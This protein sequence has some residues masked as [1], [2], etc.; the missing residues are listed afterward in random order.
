M[1]F[2]KVIHVSKSRLSYA[3]DEGTLH[4]RI[5]VG[6]GEAKGITVRA[7]DP[8]DWVKKEDSEEYIF[9]FSTARDFEM[10]KECE[11]RYHDVWFGEI[12]GIDTLRI[13][14]AFFID[15]TDG[16]QY[17]YGAEKGANLTT[18][19]TEI[20][21]IFNYFNF[22]YLNR[23]DVYHAPDWVKDTIWYQLSVNCYS[24][25]GMPCLDTRDG[26]FNGLIRKLDYIRE[27]GCSG[28]YLTPVFQSPSYHKYDTRDY[29]NV[30]E[31]MGGNAEFARF[32]K[33]AHK[34]GIRVMLDAVFNHCG[35][36]HPF[37]LDVVKNGEASKYFDCFYILDRSRPVF[38]GEILP[39][40]NCEYP[41]GKLNFRTFAYTPTMPK[42]NTGNPFVR[43]YLLGIGEKWV[44]EYGIDG[45]R[46]DVSNEI[47][48][49]FW[50]EFRKRVKGINLEVYIMGENWDDSYEWLRGEQ[51]DSV[52]NYGFLNAVWGFLA[53]GGGRTAPLTA[54]E[55]RI[56]LG[57]LAVRYPRNVGE[58]MFN[59]VT[60]HDVDRIMT[61]MKG[62]REL[63]KLAYL[64][65]LTYMGSP[66][67]YYGDEVGMAGD[68][69][70]NRVPMIW[71]EERQITELADFI[72]KMTALRREHAAF[73]SYKQD[74]L[75]CDNT[76]R[77]VIY[78]KASEQ[79]RI[80]ILVH[81][82]GE[83]AQIRLPQELAGKGVRDLAND[84]E[85]VLE[86]NLTV[87]PYGYFIWKM[88]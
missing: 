62:N 28:L 79:E 43:D 41:E 21:H 73:S 16:C 35:A 56:A 27:L 24:R 51:F 17:F 53:E 10:E 71:D 61:V 33:E 4:V 87:P 30:D 75:L 64:L 67:I 50:R 44:K 52:M 32:M 12:K 57:E 38:E 65:L 14:Y 2:S 72:R 84:R 22:P 37:W 59:L 15:G 48:H 8:F 80:V 78:E 58:H 39:D 1:D 23:E 77:T 76:T 7:V 13:R 55:F 6:K 60:S 36:H 34:R 74:W 70:H 3:Y 9:D 42:W 47:S 66:S 63:V 5:K 68:E 18:E 45:W 19:G 69:A 81:A 83:K 88:E 20:C 54:E 26:N 11:T 86:G 25:D 85:T 46:L 40:G 31:G 29:E 49:D 82:D